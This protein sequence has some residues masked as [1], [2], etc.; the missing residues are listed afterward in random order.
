[1]SDKSLA[2]KKKILETIIGVPI[3]DRKKATNGGYLTPKKDKLN[4][5]DEALN[6]KK[7][8]K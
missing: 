7:K 1:M 2:R 6:T 5:L 3:K 8:G 4:Q